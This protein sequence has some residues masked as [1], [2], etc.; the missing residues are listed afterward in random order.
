MIVDDVE[1]HH[2]AALVRGIDQRL[3]ILRPAVGAVGRVKQ[4]AVVAPVPAAGEIGDRHQLDRGEARVGDV[5]ELVDGAAKRALLGERADMQL[6]KHAFVPRPADPAARLPVI[7]WI[8]HLARPM[9]VVGLEARRRIGHLDL[10]VD[11]ER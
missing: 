8:D 1:K 2:Q 5:V 7:G 4:H 9:H 6:E 3:E 11:A 10:A